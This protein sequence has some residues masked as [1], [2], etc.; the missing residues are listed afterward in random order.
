MRPCA[1]SRIRTSLL[2]SAAIVA[3]LTSASAQ[4]TPTLEQLLG[5][6]DEYL[7]EYETQLSS[8]VAE[9]RFEQQLWGLGAKALK[10]SATLESEIAFMRLPGGA[11]WLGFRDVKR[12]N[13]KDVTPS[14]TSIADVLSSSA[15]DLTKARAIANASARHNLGL[16]RTINVPTAPLEIVHPSHRARHRYTISGEDRIKGT[17][18]IAIGFQEI[19]RPTLLRDGATGED[20]VSTGRVWINPATGTVWRVEWIYELADDR[21][22]TPTPKLRVDFEPNKAL[23]I[24]VPTVMEEIF[25][26]QGGRGEGRATYKNFRRFGTNARIVPQ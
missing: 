16:P 7:T 18:T 14:G 2:C 5:R 13:W 1:E 11:E 12:V 19:G 8:V 22:R 3:L 21:V 24:M 10:R 20:L 17:R 6:L 4:S 26:E 15:G 9:E 25:S 23:G